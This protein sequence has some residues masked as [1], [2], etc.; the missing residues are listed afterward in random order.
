MGMNIVNSGNRFQVYGEDVKTYRE[1]PVGSYNVD[2]H[3]MT[4]FFLSVRNDLAVMEEKIYGN[5]EYKVGKTLRSYRLTKRN[6]GV[7][8]GRAHV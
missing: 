8:S 5:S 2:F 4:G 7:R 3:K 6:F 1:L